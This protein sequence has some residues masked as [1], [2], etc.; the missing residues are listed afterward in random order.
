MYLPNKTPGGRAKRNVKI[1]PGVLPNHYSGYTLSD[2]W[3]TPGANVGWS[4]FLGVGTTVTINKVNGLAWTVLAIANATENALSM[5]NDEMRHLREAV[6]QNRLVLDLLTAEKGGVCK[7]LGVSCCFNIPDHS[8]NITDVIEHMRK[9]VQEPEPA[10][11]QWLT[12]IMNLEGGWGMWLAQTVLPIIVIVVLILLCIPCIIQCVSGLVQRLV[13]VGMSVQLV[14]M[15]VYPNDDVNVDDQQYDDE[16][17]GSY[18]E[19]SN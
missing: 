9:A 17:S 3:T 15:T 6:I 12:W 11:D 18:S 13:K 7:M 4:L 14:K 8:D 1:L 19:R 10:N 16:S 5:I 2:P